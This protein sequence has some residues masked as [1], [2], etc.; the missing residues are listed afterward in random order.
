MNNSATLTTQLHPATPSSRHALVSSNAHTCKSRDEQYI[1]VRVEMNSKLL[2]TLRFKPSPLKETG[3][4]ESGE[5]RARW[6]GKWRPTP[7]VW[8]WPDSAGTEAS[9]WTGLG[10]RGRQ[11]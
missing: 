8:S 4:M 2:N 9:S 10:W 11:H 7:G 1:H 3:L 6:S 5:S